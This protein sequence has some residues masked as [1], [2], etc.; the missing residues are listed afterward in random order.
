M[1]E[2]KTQIVDGVASELNAELAVR[3]ESYIQEWKKFEM[4]CQPSNDFEF[5]KDFTSFLK[6]APKENFRFTGDNN[7]CGYTAIVWMGDPS[8]EFCGITG[9]EIAYDKD[10]IK[11]FTAYHG[12]FIYPEY[13]RL[14]EDDAKELLD[15]LKEKLIAW[16]GFD[17]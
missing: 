6:Q 1:N 10:F 4:G 2:E 11:V 9:F 3:I 8:F 13:I 16:A 14:Y 12:G 17:C 5:I 7:Y 15:I